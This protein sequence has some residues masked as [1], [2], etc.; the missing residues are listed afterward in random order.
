MLLDMVKRTKALVFQGTS[1][2]DGAVIF[3]CADEETIKWLKSLTTVLTIKEGLK[4]LALGVDE[5]PYAIELWCTWR[6]LK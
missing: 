3:N 6:T 5:L 4:L 2:R 1:E